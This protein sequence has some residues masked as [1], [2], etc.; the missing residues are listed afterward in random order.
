MPL[1]TQPAAKAAAA[2]NGARRRRRIGRIRVGIRMVSRFVS[3]PAPWEDSYCVVICTPV[4][5]SAAQMA[6]SIVQRSRREP[7]LTRRA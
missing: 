5:R 2:A 3:T 6:A 7:L 1:M 4:K